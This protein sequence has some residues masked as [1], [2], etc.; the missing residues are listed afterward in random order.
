MTAARAVLAGRNR[1]GPGASLQT[2]PAP[3]THE[4]Y[5]MP[6]L[7]EQLLEREKNRPVKWYVE[8]HVTGE[9]GRYGGYAAGPFD[10]EPAAAEYM[11]ILLE[12]DHEQRIHAIRTQARRA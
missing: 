5:R 11:A 2:P 3:G 4:E 12:N 10:S 1:T 8:Y 7:A 6:S 9:P